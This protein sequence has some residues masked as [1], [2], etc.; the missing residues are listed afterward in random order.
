[1]VRCVYI[2]CATNSIPSNNMVVPRA[3]TISTHSEPPGHTPKSSLVH[4]GSKLQDAG[5]APARCWSGASSPTRWR[6]CSGLGA[7]ASA[8]GAGLKSPCKVILRA[9]PSRLELGSGSPASSVSPRWCSCG[10]CGVP[11]PRQRPR[12]LMPPPS[13]SPR[14]SEEHTS[15]LQ[16]RE[17]LVCR[18]LLEKKK[19]NCTSVKLLN[20]CF[21][22]LGDCFNTY[23]YFHSK[24][25]LFYVPSFINTSFFFI[26]ITFKLLSTN[27]YF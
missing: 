12:L 21:H 26:C 10:C 13:R 20:R 17:N 3:S 11:C 16:S 4:R 15:E 27:T 8:A 7:R 9:C 19:N 6:S 2:K 24:Q 1:T 25:T 14:R 23:R 5:R 22:L 18:L